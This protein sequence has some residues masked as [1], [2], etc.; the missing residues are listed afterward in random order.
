MPMPGLDLPYGFDWFVAMGRAFE[1]KLKPPQ[2]F[3]GGRDFVSQLTNVFIECVY[4]HQLAACG[5]KIQPT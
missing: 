5:L 2:T 4:D 3:A 1:W